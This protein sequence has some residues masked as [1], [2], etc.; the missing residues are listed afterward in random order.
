MERIVDA[1]IGHDTVKIARYTSCPSLSFSMVSKKKKKKNKK[2]IDGNNLDNVRANRRKLGIE[3]SLLAAINQMTSFYFSKRK[4]SFRRIDTIFI[5]LYVRI[6]L[7]DAFIDI[8]YWASVLPASQLYKI[9]R[10]QPPWFCVKSYQ[11][12]HIN[13]ANCSFDVKWNDKKTC[14][15]SH[16]KGCERRVKLLLPSI[17]LDQYCIPFSLL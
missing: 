16:C 17:V 12:V 1:I 6:T 15:F 4:C 14:H 10:T 3:F 2:K 8:F 13:F 5:F 11:R 7:V 9:G